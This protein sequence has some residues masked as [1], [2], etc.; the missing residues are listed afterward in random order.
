M[1]PVKI[2][3]VTPSFNQGRFIE[4]AIKSVLNQNYDHFE[5]II[6]DNCS[7]DDTLD[8]LR[9]YPHVKCVSE[10]DEGQSDAI[11]KGFKM[12]TGDIIGWL[13]ADDFYL[14]GTFHKVNQCFANNNIDAIYS[15]VKFVNS[16]GKYLRNLKSHRPL[17]WLSLLYTYIQSTSLFFRRKIVDSNII[18]DTS[19]HYCMDKDFYV[20]LLYGGYKLKY[21]DDYFAAFRWHDSNKSLAI[22]EKVKWEKALESVKIINKNTKY[23]VKPNKMN[24]FLIRRTVRYI[25]K[26]VRVL[27]KL[28]PAKH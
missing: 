10:P 23:K 24:I 13:N 6:I 25:A 22:T 20:R 7:T 28:L 26:P 15:N 12:A 21:I 1:K 3:I 4:E 27:L 19:L 17:K 14:P 8:I 16:E 9:K 18:L 5:H 11:N 2:S